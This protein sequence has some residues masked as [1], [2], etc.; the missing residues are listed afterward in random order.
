MAALEALSRRAERLGAGAGAAPADELRGGGHSD[1]VGARPYTSGDDLRDLDWAAYARFERLYI[2]ERE[3]ERGGEMRVRLDRSASMAEPR[4]W[5]EARR[6]AATLAYLGVRGGLRAR[7]EWFDGGR[8]ASLPWLLRRE[9]FLAWAAPLNTLAAGG[10]GM[11]ACTPLE[12]DLPPPSVHGE[13]VLV[14]DLLDGA[15]APDR[16]DAACRQGWHVLLLQVLSHHE[17]APPLGRY[18]ILDPETGMEV[19]IDIDAAACASYE[20]EMAALL[21]G[22]RRLALA[23]GMRHVL[24]DAR[25]GILDVLSGARMKSPA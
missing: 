14:T 21:E 11:A 18:R 24:C 8:P 2:R 20:R 22:W 16:L 3:R 7:I 19:E 13:L 23:H 17:L 9:G 10:R 4:K 15:V 1:I 25:R 5:R 12:G 6:A